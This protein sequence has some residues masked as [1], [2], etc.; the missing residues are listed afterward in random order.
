[1]PIDLVA[2]LVLSNWEL[3]FLSRQKS[4]E[5]TMKWSLAADPC[6]MKGDNQYLCK[7]S[8]VPSGSKGCKLKLSNS[9]TQAISVICFQSFGKWSKI[10][11]PLM[12]LCWAVFVPI[13]FLPAPENELVYVWPLISYP[14]WGQTVVDW[15]KDMTFTTLIMVF[16]LLNSISAICFRW[17]KPRLSVKKER[18]EKFVANDCDR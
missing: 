8:L 7:L 15:D 14:T 5:P 3:Q 18:Q 4:Y 2:K 11:V 1:M 13:S 6:V 9:V 16:W 12:D 10:V 17:W